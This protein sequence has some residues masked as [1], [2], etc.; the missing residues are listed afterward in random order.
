MKEVDALAE[1]KE[2]RLKV[3]D[4]ETQVKK[5][6]GIRENMVKGGRDHGEHGGRKEGSGKIL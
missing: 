4:L 5:E 3:M 2:L 6:G 1:L